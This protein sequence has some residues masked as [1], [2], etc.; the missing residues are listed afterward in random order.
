MSVERKSTIR[1]LR[2]EQN[3]K[4]NLPQPV[5]DFFDGKNNETSLSDE[6]EQEIQRQQE[7]LRKLSEAFYEGLDASNALNNE[8]KKKGEN[9]DIHIKTRL[10]PV[11][12]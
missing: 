7:A 5:L 3:W 9:Q 11:D 6:E 1:N 10:I 8:S 4:D 12:K 2:K